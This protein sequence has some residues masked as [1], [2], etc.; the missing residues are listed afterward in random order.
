MPVP[1]VGYWVVG[2]GCWVLRRI[3]R[4]GQIGRLRPN[5]HYPIP[6]TLLRDPRRVDLLGN[7]AAVEE[8]VEWDRLVEDA[9]LEGVAHD[10]VHVVVGRGERRIADAIGRRG[11]DVADELLVL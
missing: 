2:V 1:G 9:G 4:I 7:E 3:G 11:Q 6:N 8:I 5:T 10:L